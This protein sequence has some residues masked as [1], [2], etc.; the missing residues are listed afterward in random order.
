V[1]DRAA[2]VSVVLP[3]RDRWGLAWQAL[4]T[5]L[6][7][8]AVQVEVC[9]VDDGSLRPAPSGVADDA[10]VR[11]FRHESAQG[12]AASRNH[13]IREARGQWIAFLDD[14]DVWAPW[15]LRRLL[16]AAGEAGARWGFSGHVATSLAR[17]PLA[18]GPI[19]A[20]EPDA[21]RQFL[22]VNSIGTP[23]SAIVEAETL[24]RV[25]GFDERLS[26]LADWDLWVRLAKDGPPAVNAEFTVG[27][28]HHRG[29]MSL[30][31]DRARTEL[32]YL[33]R[34]YGPEL[35][36][37]GVEFGDNHYFWRWFARAYAHSR[38]RGLALRYFVRA[39]RRGG[40][41]RDVVRGAMQIPVI[42]WP[43]RF[44]RVLRSLAQRRSRAR[45][46]LRATHQWLQRL[47]VSDSPRGRAVDPSAGP[48]SQRWRVRTRPSP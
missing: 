18:T 4:H 23:S 14:D 40:G 34:R 21:V 12:V 2:E 44:A 13:G 32:A 43:L 39:A 19:P 10:R 8:Q 9:V 17:V 28:A 41:F 30:H 38:R 47:G 37:A 3:T 25:G 11:V 48:T 29:S 20:V 15:H 5:A 35:E 1:T 27:Y 31:A 16:D 26:V 24:R 6:E 42:G 33:S 46:E 36:A 22:C 45:R 7:Q